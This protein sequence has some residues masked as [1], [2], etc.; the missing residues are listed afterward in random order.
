MDEVALKASLPLP[1]P[2]LSEPLCSIPG[3]Q[4][5]TRLGAG[6]QDRGPELFPPADAPRPHG[7]S[8]WHRDQPLTSS[9]HLCP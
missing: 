8:G 7:C 6:G 1:G 4:V 5:A 9:Y 2:F 3:V